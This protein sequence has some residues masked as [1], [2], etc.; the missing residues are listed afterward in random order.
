MT[1]I[2][3]TDG[4]FQYLFDHF[5]HDD[6]LIAEA[7]RQALYKIHVPN[8]TGVWPEFGARVYQDNG[9]MGSGYLMVHWDDSGKV[10]GCQ[11]NGY[12]VELF[13]RSDEI[14]WDDQ[15]ERERLQ[16]IRQTLSHWAY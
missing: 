16:D 10:P 5:P 11:S 8:P 4:Q 14:V 13:K 1:K 6:N 12:C 15:P 7:C 9:V 2:E 3:L